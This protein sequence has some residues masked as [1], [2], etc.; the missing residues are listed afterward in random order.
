[1]YADIESIL[2]QEKNWKKNPEEYYTNKYQKHIACKYGYQLVCAD[3]K[4]HK[5]F[6]TYLGKNAIH[7]FIN[8][9]IR[10]SK[11][12]SDAM[13]EHFNEE[14]VM[15][16]EDNEILRTLLNVGFVITIILIMILK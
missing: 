9:M 10:E 15:T 4:F 2:I 1:M 11:Y 8:S 6:N 16:E 5:P 12:C 14:L 7:N 3:D 13:K